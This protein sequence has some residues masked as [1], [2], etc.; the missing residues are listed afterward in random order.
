MLDYK[1]FS[2]VGPNVRDRYRN[3]IFRKAKDVYGNSFSSIYD[4]DYK[5]RKVAGKFKRFTRAEKINAPVLTGDLLRDYSLI[6]TSTNGFQIGWIAQG[7]KIKWLANNRRYLTTKE[8]PLPKNI[9]DYLSKEACAYTK[10]KSD[11]KLGIGKT[12]IHKIGK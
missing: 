11:K 9:M 6:K 7:A 1:F 8:D 3:H 4:K 12:K 10:K 2:K 5:S